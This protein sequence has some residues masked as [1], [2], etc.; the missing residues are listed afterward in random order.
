MYDNDKDDK[1]GPSMACEHGEHIV[2]KQPMDG[3]GMAEAGVNVRTEPNA[4]NSS[5]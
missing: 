2:K 4:N 3:G 5:N 1:N